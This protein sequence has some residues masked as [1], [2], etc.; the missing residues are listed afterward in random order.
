MNTTSKP[1]EHNLASLK[2]DDHSRTQFKKSGWKGKAAGIALAVVIA[3]VLLMAL[4]PRNPIVQVA[5]ARTVERAAGEVL[6]NA[7]G[8]VTAQRRATVAAK[9]TG[10]VEQIYAREGLVVNPGQV[11]ATLECS[12]PRA[13]VSAAKT[14]RDVSAASLNDLQVQLRNADRELQRAKGL[15]EA[16]VISEELLDEKRTA[17]DSLRSKI[18]LVQEQI[19]AADARVLLAQEDVDNCTV[20]AP[21]RGI[22]ISKDADRGEIVSPVSA[23]GGFTRTGIATLVDMKSLELEVDVNES[24]IARIKPGQKVIAVLDAYPSWQIPATVRTVI[25][26][27]DRQKATVKV[28]ISLNQMDNRILPDMS[29]KVEFLADHSPEPDRS[30]AP[31][32][33]IPRN[34]VRSD[35]AGTFVFL[36]VNNIVKRRDI[37][38]GSEHN[39]NVD[40]L[41]G[42]AGGDAVIINSSGNLFDGQAVDIRH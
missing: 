15:H 13:A 6:L 42:I 3:A 12:Q 29:A 32:V 34:A 23:G 30:L 11:L 7:S 19:R 35:S 17:A 2:I 14:D 36:V 24:Y 16:G 5:F 40:V 31:K 41:N 9:V 4:R 1:P 26:S 25:P 33:A 10:R 27:A 39:G 20:R 21:F 28:R 8:Y 18:A 38:V 22:V 37:S